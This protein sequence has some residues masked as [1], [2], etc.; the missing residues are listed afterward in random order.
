MH[1][2]EFYVTHFNKFGLIKVIVLINCKDKSLPEKR[3]RFDFLVT[4]FFTIFRSWNGPK[5]SL[6]VP[7]S[8]VNVSAAVW[9]TDDMRKKTQTKTTTM[10][11][12]K[13]AI[14][15]FK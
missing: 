3:Q 14:K 12:P 10:T 2:G 11:V 13:R 7:V 15:R 8:N 9:N 1:T 6:P 4:F 5:F